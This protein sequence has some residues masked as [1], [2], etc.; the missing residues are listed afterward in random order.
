MTDK[1]IYAFI[2]GI[3]N[4]PNPKHRLSG[5]VPDTGKIVGFLEETFPADK[6]F[7]K[8]L[9]DEEATYRNFIDAFRSHLGQ[10]TKDD[11]VWFHYSGHGARQPTAVELEKY[12]SGNMDETLVLYDSRPD[13]RDLADRELGLLI[14]EVEQSGAHILVTLDCCHSGSGTRDLDNIAPQYTE[15]LTENRTEK[16]MLDSYL[17]GFYT[18][19]GLQ[20]PNPKHILLAACNRFQTAKETYTSSGVFTDNL[21]RT[22]KQ[23][24][25]EISYAD[26][27]VRMRQGVISNNIPDQDPQLELMGGTNAHVQFLNGTRLG[28]VMKY[29]VYYN[30][31]EWIMGAGAIQGLQ[32]AVEKGTD[33]KAIEVLIYKGQEAEPYTT[34][35]ITSVSFQKSILKSKLPLLEDEKYWGIPDRLAYPPEKLFFENDWNGAKQYEAELK[36]YNGVTKADSNEQKLAAYSLKVN[37]D[38]VELWDVNQKQLLQTALINDAEA[39]S[40]LSRLLNQVVVWK[41]IFSLQNTNA[42]IKPEEVSVVMQIKEGDG[43]TNNYPPGN[44]YFE[45]KSVKYYYQISVHNTSKQPLHFC[46]LYLSAAY[47][48]V[49]LKN[50]PIES[51]EKFTLFWG[52]S[53]DDYFF[54]EEGNAVSADTFLLIVSTERTDDF[55]LVL[56]EINIGASVSKVTTRAVAGVNKFIPLKGEWFTQKFTIRIG[57]EQ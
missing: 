7:I 27:F 21:I 26:L 34:A 28:T 38:E 45:N 50:E 42:K 40:K 5:A 48:S 24:G 17:D 49:A 56:D 52:G 54:L 22:L 51:S 1:N 53:D 6:L 12:T 32:N 20:F 19:N 4:Y 18:K 39:P 10:A 36:L 2:V 25:C 8:L 55:D 57:N 9:K 23:T 41:R 46:L 35:T 37:G 15:R 33:E 30:E 43:E 16:R 14:A 11:I 3:N 13:G 47:G 31:R 29:P 44:I